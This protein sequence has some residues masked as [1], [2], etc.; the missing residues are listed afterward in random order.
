MSENLSSPVLSNASQQ[1]KDLAEVSV[2]RLLWRFSIPATV[3]NLVMAGYT[4]LK[5]FVRSI[6]IL[7]QSAL[8]NALNQGGNETSL[9]MPSSR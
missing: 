2:G 3:G 6:V 4:N 1:T 5:Y 8:V 7:I 9:L